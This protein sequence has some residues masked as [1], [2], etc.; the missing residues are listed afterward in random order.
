M[1]NEP[2]KPFLSPAPL[3]L[4]TPTS[5]KDKDKGGAAL[6]LWSSASSTDKLAGM[7]LFRGANQKSGGLM[8]RLK[9]L[10]T[11]DVAF[12]GAGLAVLVMAPLAE[13]L[14]S[15][16]EDKAGQLQGGFASNSSPF[17]EGRDPSEIGIMGL[18]RGGV[19]GD[20][21]DVITPLN[22]RD[23]SSLIMGGNGE[24]KE[25]P[26][27][28]SVE[29]KRDAPK[30]SVWDKV[31]S[32]AKSGATAATRKVSLPKPGGKLAGAI[33][34]LRSLS[35]GSTG[36]SLK[37]AAPDS[38][39]LFSSPKNE[40]HLAATQ[41]VPGYRGA[42]ARVIAGGSGGNTSGRPGG[43]FGG[44]GGGVAG[45]VMSGGISGGGRGS[46]FSGGDGDP[47]KNPGGS[48]TKDAKTLGESLAFLRQKMEMEKAIDLKWAKK[49]YDELERKKMIE[50]TLVQTAQQAFMK[51]LDKLLEGKKDGAGGG[52]SGGGGSPPGGGAPGGKEPPAGS[53]AGTPSAGRG[54]LGAVRTVAKP[55]SAD[56]IKGQITAAES[57]HK[58]TDQSLGELG[59]NAGVLKSKAATLA[60]SSDPRLQ[61]LAKPLEAAASDLAAAE[62]TLREQIAEAKKPLENHKEIQ[63]A[64]E[65]KVK[66]LKEAGTLGAAGSDL[67]MAEPAKLTDDGTTYTGKASG[68]DAGAKADEAKAKADAAKHDYKAADFPKDSKGSGEL[69][70]NIEKRIAAVESA[71]TLDAN[72]RVDPAIQASLAAAKAELA[73]ILRQAAQNVRVA[74]KNLQTAVDASKESATR[75]NQVQQ[76]YAAAQYAAGKAAEDLKKAAGK[77]DPLSDKWKGKVADHPEYKEEKTTLEGDIKTA[78]GKVKDAVKDIQRSEKKITS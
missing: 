37:L 62:K 21:S 61:S 30:D 77:I 72:A 9:S 45:D 68:K 5:S 6:P 71:L 4:P 46:G 29:P 67:A 3:P 59:Q 36:A 73:G 31:V 8:G 74:D 26:A 51:V 16:G 27:T 66:G 13:Y 52:G 25:A 75:A 10:K 40:S 20:G 55:A 49:R 43:G 78:D 70:A 22:A 1:A 56:G 48:S 58:D 14:I 50:Q 60:A 44:P 7:P 28:A 39:G 12:I 19:P 42:G 76:G 65:T 41:P 63:K 24:Q 23:P 35:G 17:N 11:K 33:N 47:T 57:T 2:R 38:K 18:A 15:E 54:G 53:P 32:S 64:L 34:G 69:A